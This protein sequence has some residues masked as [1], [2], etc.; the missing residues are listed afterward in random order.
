[1]LVLPY[2]ICFCLRDTQVLMLYR[3]YPPNAGRWNGL[4]GHIEAAETPLES[5]KR[6]V[7]E[8][9]GIDLDLA[10]GLNFTGLV[11]WATD[12][13]STRP[14]GGMY[15]FVARLASDFPIWPDRPIHE[16]LLSWK[17]LA[18]VCDPR[19]PAIVSNIPQFLP[20]MLA[21]PHPQEYCCV[22][23]RSGLRGVV[24]RDLPLEGEN[25]S[26]A[27]IPHMEARKKHESGE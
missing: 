25:L 23:R 20:Q 21:N 19:N 6:E 16:G 18:W 4:G 5:I 22:Y 3:S 15:T 1:M 27:S 17:P 9:G 13:D 24:V 14:G 26:F 12:G 2:T 11:T 10:Q 7:M 8:E